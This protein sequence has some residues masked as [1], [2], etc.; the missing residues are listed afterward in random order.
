MKRALI[1]VVVLALVASGYWYF[2]RGKSAATAT[3]YLT[4][5][6]TRGNVSA[7]IAATGA[8]Q[9]ATTY[10][11]SFGQTTVSAASGTTSTSGSGSGSSSNSNSNSV[12]STN[13]VTSVSAVVGKHVVKGAVLA[14]QDGTGSAAAVAA[15]QASVL[16]SQAQVANANSQL[17][18]TQQKIAGQAS[19]A[20]QVA[21][22]KAQLAVDQAQLAADVT[23]LAGDT[24]GSLQ[25]AKDNLA[26]VRDRAAIFTDQQNLKAADNTAFT[27]AA[28][29]AALAQAQAA[30][31]QANN[32]VLTANANLKTAET[33]AAATTIKAPVSGVITA[34]NLTVG[35]PPPS[36]TAVSMRSD[37]LA[38]VASI[39]E[40]DEPNLTAGLSAQ[41]N[42]ASLNQSVTASLLSL[43]TSATSGSSGSG[44]VTFPATFLL[45]S[46]PA[47][48]LPG[49]TASISITTATATNVI[50]VPSSAIQ[51]TSP[52]YSVQVMA[53]GK[54]VSTP[55]N[56]GLTTN[57]LTE[58]ISGLS[59]GQIVVTGTVSQ[60]ATT[61]GG[62]GGSGGRTLGG[63]G[64]GGFRPGGLGG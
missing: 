6:V 10:A 28:N 18:G 49:M 36:G 56:V 24:L 38:V 43:P 16:V 60:L 15:A 22:A 3:E 19:T 45:Q 48:L 34:V 54:P 42:I 23:K 32:G 50:E 33:A 29:A 47:G 64:G 12:A 27:Q 11:L 39:A 52:N 2:G 20:S 5:A 13:L 62:T 25:Y 37:N 46:N 21:L 35:N 14:A 61:T 44:A 58:I 53:N 63:T 59:V 30:V 40:Q 17:Q 9:S 8:V 57:S 41:V 7:T 26:V 51:G 1:V 31:T 4:T 55:V